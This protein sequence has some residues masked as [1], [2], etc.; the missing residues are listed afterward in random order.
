MPSQLDTY[1]LLPSGCTL[2]HKVC[3]FSLL[4]IRPAAH[5]SAIQPCFMTGLRQLELVYKSYSFSTTAPCKVA[6]QAALQGFWYDCG[7]N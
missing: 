5:G 2:A 1:V 7:F 4:L 6:C 3:G